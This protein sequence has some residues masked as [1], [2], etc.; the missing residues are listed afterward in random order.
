MSDRVVKDTLP[1][2]EFR[3]VHDLAVP[4][5]LRERLAHEAEEV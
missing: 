4:L 1:G 3:L 2:C 5:A